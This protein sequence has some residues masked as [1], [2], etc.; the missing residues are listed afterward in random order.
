MNHPEQGRVAAAI[1]ALLAMTAACGLD[2]EGGLLS[3]D[4]E[5]LVRDHE[6]SMDVLLPEYV[7]KSNRGGRGSFDIDCVPPQGG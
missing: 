1:A 6:D 7:A 3:P 5:E 4:A 2:S